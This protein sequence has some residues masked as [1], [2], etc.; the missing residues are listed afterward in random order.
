[1]INL[2]IGTIHI[3]NPKAET[4]IN[5]FS[6]EEIR[7]MF[8]SFLESNHIYNA[9]KSSKKKWANFADRMSGLTT[10]EITEHINN[11]SKEIRDSFHFRNLDHK[12]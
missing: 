5:A 2:E 12:D 6:T 10:P 9:S 8:I 7:S 4:V 3:D 1:M 11:T